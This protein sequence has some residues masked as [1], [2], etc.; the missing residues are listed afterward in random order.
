[1][2]TVKM[3]RGHIFFTIIF[4]AATL[5]TGSSFAEE[6]QASKVFERL[7]GLEG[8]WT[9]FARQTSG[10]PHHDG[11]DEEMSVLHEFRVSAA[12]SVVMEIMGPDSPYE[13]IN[14]YHLDG[15]DLVLTHYC[16]AGNQPTMKLNPAAGST[17]NLVFEFTGGTNF[18]PDVDH[19]IHSS[20]IIFSGEGTLE[21]YWTSYREGRQEAEMQFSLKRSTDQ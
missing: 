6:S 8:T 18:N 9:G 12:G 16:A 3:N 17:D 1:M 19:H 21:S 15:Q 7:K 4:A 13:M 11:A 14:M 10:E 5:F 2:D 20:R